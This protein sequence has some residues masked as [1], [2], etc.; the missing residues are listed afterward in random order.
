M[1]AALA[2]GGGFPALMLSGLPPPH[3]VNNKPMARLPRYFM[4][5]ICIMDL[6]KEYKR[7]A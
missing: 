1:V 4:G 5:F 2:G 3:A 7:K 6:S